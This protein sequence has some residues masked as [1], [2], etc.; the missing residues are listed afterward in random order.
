MDNR[1][2]T[3]RIQAINTNKSNFDSFHKNIEIPT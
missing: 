2:G 1:I 3:N